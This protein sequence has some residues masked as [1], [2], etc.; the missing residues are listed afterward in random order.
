MYAILLN[1]EEK[2][3][4]SIVADAVAKNLNEALEIVIKKRFVATEQG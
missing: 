3:L 1:R 2:A 4:S